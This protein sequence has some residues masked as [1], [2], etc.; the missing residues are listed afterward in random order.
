MGIRGEGASPFS[1][2]TQ[3]RKRPSPSSNFSF[4]LSQY[5]SLVP[6]FLLPFIDFTVVESPSPSSETPLAPYIKERLLSLLCSLLKEGKVLLLE[7]IDVG[8]RRELYQVRT[9]GGELLHSSSTSSL[10]TLPFP[11]SLSWML[12]QIAMLPSC[13]LSFSFWEKSCVWRLWDGRREVLRRRDSGSV[14]GTFF[15]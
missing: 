7:D 9:Q 10:M 14:R 2:G 12:S 4:S 8:I 1:R 15:S 13:S 5:H 6:K 3:K 11:K